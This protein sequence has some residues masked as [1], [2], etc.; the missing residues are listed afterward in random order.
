MVPFPSGD[1]LSEI[2]VCWRVAVPAGKLLMM[3]RSHSYAAI[4][5]SMNV[6]SGPE[7]LPRTLLRLLRGSGGA[8]GHSAAMATLMS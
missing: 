5:D 2:L 7:F 1:V 6:S 4:R 3:S 8:F